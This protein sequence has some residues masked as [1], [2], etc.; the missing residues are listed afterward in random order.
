MKKTQKEITKDIS[1]KKGWE[2][3]MNFTTTDLIKLPNNLLIKM[4][5]MLMKEKQRREV[6]KL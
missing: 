2:C 3:V 6:E 5:E 1:T 4:A